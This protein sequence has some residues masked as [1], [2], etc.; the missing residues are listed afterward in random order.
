MILERSVFALLPLVV[1]AIPLFCLALRH[2]F[3]LMHGMRLHL[4]VPCLALAHF[5]LPVRV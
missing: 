1:L 2:V 4:P 5:S 3:L